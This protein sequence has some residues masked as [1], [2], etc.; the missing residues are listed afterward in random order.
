MTSQTDT[1]AIPTTTRLGPD[2][3]RL[4][5]ALR[6]AAEVESAEAPV[7]T[8]YLDLRPEAHGER[9]GARAELIAIRD[10]LD[11]LVEEHHPH[12]PARGS[13]D[14]DRRRLDEL[15]GT[16]PPNVE[17][18]AVFACSAAGLWEAVVAAE[19]FKTDAAAGPIAD[20]YQ[21]AA[22]A[23]ADDPAVVALVDIHSCR[24]FVRRRGDLVERRGPEEPP[25]EHRRHDQGGWSQARYQRHVDEQDRRFARVAAEAID[26]LTER[27]RAVAVI[28]GAEERASSVLLPALA[29]RTRA[30]VVDVRHISMHATADEV[31]AEV[32]PLLAALDEDRARQ[33]ADRALAGVAAGELGL[34]GARPVERALEAGAVAELVLDASRVQGL[35][36][37]D[38]ARLVRRAILTDARVVVVHDH[39]ELSG[40][41]GVAATLRFRP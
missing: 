1:S 22:L 14:A 39:A 23:G 11:E 7:V 40:G 35:D 12:T 21:L 29:E 31:E 34:I 37:W 25:D 8:A 2:P 9:P 19:P 17:G 32:E 15:L 10:R 16:V 3:A 33:A 24:L 38:R 5:D 18:L 13:L 28:I 26:R 36:R 6:R 20:L 27:E 41:D 30:L 4:R